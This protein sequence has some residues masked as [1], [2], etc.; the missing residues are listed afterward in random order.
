MQLSKKWT[1]AA[2]ISIQI[3][4]TSFMINLNN[5]NRESSIYGLILTGI[6]STAL[7]IITAIRDVHG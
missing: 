1:I 6:V 4:V 2:Y 5:E 7:Y 3:A